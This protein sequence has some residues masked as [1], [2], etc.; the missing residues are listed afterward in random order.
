M[1][2]LIEFGKVILPAAVVLYGMFLTTRMFI[3]KEYDL[4]LIELRN[5]NTEV[6]IPLRLQAYERICL[7]LERIT[8]KN[9]LIRLNNPDLSAADFQQ[10]LVHEIREE[11]NHNLS[12]Q[13]YMSE[14]SWDWVKNAM[15]EV[16]MIINESRGLLNEEARGIELARAIF[17]NLGQRQQLGVESALS[18][19]KGEIQQNF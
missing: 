1:E 2:A 16:I 9:L 14:T 15:E 17:E 10:L 8:P 11:F 19:I 6:I 12:Q 5:K 7:F 13:V 4:K 18:F 3:R